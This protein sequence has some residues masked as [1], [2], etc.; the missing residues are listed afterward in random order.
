MN[1]IVHYPNSIEKEQELENKLTEVHADIV[2]K[3]IQ[4][5]IHSKSEAEKLINLICEKVQLHNYQ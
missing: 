3:Y 1:I 4:K 2:L 5:N